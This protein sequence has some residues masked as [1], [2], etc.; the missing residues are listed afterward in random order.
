MSVPVS[1]S[2]LLLIDV[3]N[4]LAFEGAEALVAAAEAMAGSLA[5][6]KRRAAATGVPA[7]YLSGAFG[8]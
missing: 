2:A 8:R 7:I 4:D 1:G 3:I 6:L 5:A